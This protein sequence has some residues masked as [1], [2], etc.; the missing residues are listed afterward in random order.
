[1]NTT[2]KTFKIDAGHLEWNDIKSEL[3]GN[4]I[5]GYQIPKQQ[6]LTCTWSFRVITEHGT[7]IVLSS[8]TGDVDGWQEAG[9]MKL[10]IKEYDLLNG[11][12]D[13]FSF[14]S[15]KPFFIHALELM[16]YSCDEYSSECCL[17]FINDK[18]LR[19][20]VSTSPAPGAVSVDAEFNEGQFSPEY[21]F[22][23]CAIKKCY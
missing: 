18:T 17:V 12:N 1:M 10:V 4:N 6:N 5:I 9:F 14:F 21:L 11:E 7:A 15:I 3:I 2:F 20:S 19:I 23:D 22:E 8:A 13:G 16:V